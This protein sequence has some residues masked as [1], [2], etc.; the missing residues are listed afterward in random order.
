MSSLRDECA[1]SNCPWYFWD[2]NMCSFSNSQPKA[3]R[4]LWPSINSSNESIWPIVASVS[5]SLEWYLNLSYSF[6]YRELTGFIFPVDLEEDLMMLLP[7]LVHL[8]RTAYQYGYVIGAIE[9]SSNNFLD[10]YCYSLDEAEYE[11]YWSSAEALTQTQNSTDSEYQRP[12]SFLWIE[13]WNL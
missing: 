2:T 5:T 7:S 13:S 10:C 8:A 3:A 6:F 1:H 4:D 9:R 12:R 11:M